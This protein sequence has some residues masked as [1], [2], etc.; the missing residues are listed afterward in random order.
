[1]LLVSLAFKEPV[2]RLS[3]SF[4]K[5]KKKPIFYKRIH[6]KPCKESTRTCPQKNR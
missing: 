6:A 5:G 2:A 1:M 4:I 3:L